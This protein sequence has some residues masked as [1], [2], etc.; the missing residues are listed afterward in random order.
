MQGCECAM[1]IEELVRIAAEKLK[2]VTG[3]KPSTVIG[4]SAV[5]DGWRVTVEMVEKAAIPDAMDVLGIYDVWV[6][7]EGKLLR[8]ERKRLRKRGETNGD[9]GLV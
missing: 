6:D 5:E 1:D 7:P 9:S 2:A 4:I 8:F 3:L